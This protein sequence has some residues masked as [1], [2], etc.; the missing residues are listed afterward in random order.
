MSKKRIIKIV[1][2]IIVFA[3]VIIFCTW[4]LDTVASSP[5]FT[6]EQRSMI[7]SNFSLITMAFF[8]VSG[9]GIG[10]LLDRF[11][12]KRNLVKKEILARVVRYFVIVF[13]IIIALV[14]MCV[15]S[16]LYYVVPAVVFL[17]VIV[18]L[19]SVKFA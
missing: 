6:E 11:L 15:N 18:E 12:K 3:L 19:L 5:E 8:A 4:V 9:F 1:A 10:W 7:L 13:A 17:A 16:A 14:L 2:S